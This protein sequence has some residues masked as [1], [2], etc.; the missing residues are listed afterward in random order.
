MNKLSRIGISFVIIL[1][2]LLFFVSFI[3]TN[4]VSATLVQPAPTYRLEITNLPQADYLF[5]PF[6]KSDYYTDINVKDHMLYLRYLSGLDDESYEAL[7]DDYGLIASSDCFF[8]SCLCY[9][10]YEKMLNIH[11]VRMV[12]E[13]LSHCYS[14]KDVGFCPELIKY[15]QNTTEIQCE[16]TR[17]DYYGSYTHYIQP[18]LYDINHDTFYSFPAFNYEYEDYNTKYTLDYSKSNRAFTSGKVVEP[19]PMDCSPVYEESCITPGIV[20][21][22]KMIQFSDIVAILVLLLSALSVEI[23]ITALFGFDKRSLIT[24]FIVALIGWIIFGVILFIFSSIS[25]INGDAV[26]IMAVATLIVLAFTKPLIYKYKCTRGDLG[27]NRV[28]KIG[29][30]SNVI[31]VSFSLIVIYILQF[32]LML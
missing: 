7:M 5:I 4:E 27:I 29:F 14:D 16:I 9:E 20:E 22:I 6:I 8:Y 30:L 12:D 32:V 21:S 26:A 25:F 2:V 31:C 15:Y 11:Y 10:K 1:L 17:I 24:V 19:P 3:F 23:A 18:Y 13:N 28:Y